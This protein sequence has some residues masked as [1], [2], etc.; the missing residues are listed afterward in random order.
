MHPGEY[1]VV[2]GGSAPAPFGSMVLGGSEGVRQRFNSPIAAQRL[3]ALVEARQYGALELELLTQALQDKAIE[4]QKA[5]YLRL[6]TRTEAAAERA[7][8]AYDPYVLFECLAT[9]AGHWAGVTAVAISPDGR[10]LVSGS[11]DKTIIVW[12][13]WA[14][15]AIFTLKA[16]S[17]IYAIT[18]SDDGETFAMRGRDHIVKAWHLRTGKQIHPEKG[19][20]R[21][22]ASVTLTDDRHL[23]SSSQ[24]AIKIWNLK[25]G[26]ELCTLQG[27]TSLVTA[28]AVSADKQLIISGSEDRTVRVWGVA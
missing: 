26:R 9:L 18:V 10:S 5:A 15:E 2:L 14:Q 28:V 13:W 3:A 16:H 19:A 17:F 4:V 23:I 7:L 27:H 11:R 22:I 21:T 20:L 12:D 25:S 8:A 1:D 6:Q 24:N